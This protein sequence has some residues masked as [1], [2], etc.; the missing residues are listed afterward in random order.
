MLKY[1][2]FISPL[3]VVVYTP[4]RFTPYRN[5][6]Q[7]LEKEEVKNKLSQKKLRYPRDSGYM[8]FPNTPEEILENEKRKE[9]QLGEYRLLCP[10]TKNN[11]FPI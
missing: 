4:P 11:I 10:P 9:R 7:M 3:S 2:L 1:N 6:N 8:S 5:K